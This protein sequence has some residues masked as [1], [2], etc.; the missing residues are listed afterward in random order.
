MNKEIAFGAVVLIGSFVLCGVLF[1][2]ALKLA[3][4][5]GR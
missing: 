3:T 5:L 1:H 2:E 4:I